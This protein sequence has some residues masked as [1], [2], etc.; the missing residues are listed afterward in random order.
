MKVRCN[1]CMNIFDEEQIILDSE[2][3]DYGSSIE[4]CPRCGKKGCLMDLEDS[5]SQ[6]E[7]QELYLGFFTGK[8]VDKKS[9]RLFF[10]DEWESCLCVNANEVPQGYPDYGIFK[11]IRLH[12]EWVHPSKLT[13]K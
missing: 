12:C 1:Q 7:T 2:R 10:N 8:V 5:Q 13:E 3:R 11:V 9:V 6:E 4:K